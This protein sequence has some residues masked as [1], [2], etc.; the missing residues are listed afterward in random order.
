MF[1][2]FNNL[3][4]SVSKTAQALVGSVV[5]VV[6]GENEFSEFVLEEM[7]DSLISADLGVT[8]A[9]EL[10]D[11]IRDNAN[12]K[13]NQIKNFLKKEFLETLEKAGSSKLSY[14]EN[15]LNIYFITGV[16]GA[17]KTTLIG[18]M[19]YKFKELGKKVLIAAGDT[20]R[21]AAEEQAEIWSKRSGADIIRKD[22]ADPASVVYEAIQ[23]AKN[24]KY[25][26]IL[27]DTAGRLQ[28]KFNLMEELSKIKN[29][30]DKNAPEALRESLLVID[31]NTGQNGL[32]QAKI[33]KDCVN[34]TAVALT[35]LDGSARGAIVLAI[36]KE[37]SL[38]VKLIGVG[39]K[40]E[41]LK[42][43]DP[44]AFIEALF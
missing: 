8:Y 35:K 20:F 23:K 9:T 32:Q 4:K 42:D 29:V 37:M 38:P 44:N 39:E 6:S 27:V 17:G 40:M 24:E 36:A 41:D 33:F 16:N 28:N 43:F 15:E 14:K 26:V 30:I 5:D 31:A 11:K 7:E 21:A 2:F 19:A 25:D 12:L 10:T 34:L 13:P 3:K 22:K 18:K 1:N